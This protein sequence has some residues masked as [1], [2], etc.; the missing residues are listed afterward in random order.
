MSTIRT[1]THKRTCLS[2]ACSEG[3]VPAH[4]YKF[5]LVTVFVK[6]P[7]NPFR[8]L[9]H[10]RLVFGS[11]SNLVILDKEEFLPWIINHRPNFNHLYSVNR[12]LQ[13]LEYVFSVFVSISSKSMLLKP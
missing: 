9:R 3:P 12:L 6:L 13:A 4:F 10:N 2:R 1:C 5:K 7:L 8:H 11:E